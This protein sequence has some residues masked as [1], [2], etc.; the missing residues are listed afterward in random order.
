MDWERDGIDILST[1]IRRGIET[2]GDTYA[3][4]NSTTS[5]LTWMDENPD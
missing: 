3:M 1:V 5:S 2:R 4:S